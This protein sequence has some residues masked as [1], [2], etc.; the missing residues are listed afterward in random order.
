MCR[1][2]HVFHVYLW[3]ESALKAVLTRM[4]STMFWKWSL[5]SAAYV[6][7][8]T[9]LLC[10]SWRNQRSNIQMFSLVLSAQHS[11]RCA[12][13]Q[14]T[15]LEKLLTVFCR[16]LFPLQGS[17]GWQLTPPLRWERWNYTEI[18]PKQNLESL[19]LLKQPKLE[20]SVHCSI[21]LQVTNSENMLLVSLAGGLGLKTCSKPGAFS[22][23]IDQISTECQSGSRTGS[24]YCNAECR[25]WEVL[26][27]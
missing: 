13:C 9:K 1:T 20:L 14:M 6:Q 27:K 8:R 12:G 23:C 17:R 3:G 25:V 22:K 5:R 4:V 10:T 2:S 21:G 7:K 11:A 26:P 19:Q 16:D 18:E 15:W 24:I